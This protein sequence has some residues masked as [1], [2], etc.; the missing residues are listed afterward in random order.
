MEKL[1]AKILDSFILIFVAVTF[2]IQCHSTFYTIHYLAVQHVCLLCHGYTC[3]VLLAKEERLTRFYIF[4]GSNECSECHRLTF[5]LVPTV[6]VHESFCISI[7]LNDMFFCWYSLAWSMLHTCYSIYCFP[8]IYN[9]CALY[10]LFHLK[11][12]KL[13]ISSIFEVQVNSYLLCWL[14]KIYT[15]HTLI[16]LN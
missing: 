15:P 9:C 5:M 1:V 3:R 7:V 16:K 4:Q 6:T 11:G 13:Y 2:S 8:S 12:N 14:F 10:R